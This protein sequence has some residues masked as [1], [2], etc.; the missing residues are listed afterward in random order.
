[1]SKDQ[2]SNYFLWASTPYLWIWICVYEFQLIK[3]RDFAHKFPT[4]WKSFCDPGSRGRD[5]FHVCVYQ[6][7]VEIMLA[8]YHFDSS[9]FN[10]LFL[11]I[12]K[13]IHSWNR[14]IKCTFFL[15]GIVYI[16]PT[17][18][19][20]IDHSFFSVGGIYDHL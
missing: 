14:W 8:S 16:A 9:S 3:T 20:C 10:F 2:I 4:I 12:V 15:F 13:I 18:W 19:N 11:Q 1:M 7:S 5:F 6:D 17:L